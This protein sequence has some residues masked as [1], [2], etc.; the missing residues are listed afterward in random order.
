MVRFKEK[1]YNSNKIVLYYNNNKII[2]T[3]NL[4][5]FNF[6]FITKKDIQVLLQLIK[7]KWK[8]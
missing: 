1:K 6:K 3:I 7:C 8:I 5:K 4:V 2:I